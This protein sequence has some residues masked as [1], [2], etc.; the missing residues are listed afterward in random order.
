MVGCRD[1]SAAH[2]LLPRRCGPSEPESRAD[3][4]IFTSFIDDRSSRRQLKLSSVKNSQA[5]DLE[6]RNGILP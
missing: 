1:V 2:Q 3:G 5:V 4:G 6:S